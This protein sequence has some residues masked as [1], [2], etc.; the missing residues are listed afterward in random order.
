MEMKVEV[1][2]F[3]YSRDPEENKFQVEFTFKPTMKANEGD[4]INIVA[5]IESVFEPIKKSK[6]QSIT[7][8]NSVSPS[9]F[10]ISK[11]IFPR[12]M[13]NTTLANFIK[14]KSWGG[15]YETEIEGN[16]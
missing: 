14:M 10:L 3:D 4:V 13:E 11:S 9:N 15:V 2:H 12:V 1:C 7:L 8:S 5:E 16:T 6:T